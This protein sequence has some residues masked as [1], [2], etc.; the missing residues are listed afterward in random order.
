MI[1]RALLLYA[2]KDL[3]EGCSGLYRE[4]WCREFGW[5]LLEALRH[6]RLVPDLMLS[7]REWCRTVMIGVTTNYQAL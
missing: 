7:D 1:S 2:S 3:A 5:C 6:S 4:D